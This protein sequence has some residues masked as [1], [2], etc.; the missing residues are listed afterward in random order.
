MKALPLPLLL[1]V[2]GVVLVGGLGTPCAGEEQYYMY[3][4][5]RMPCDV[6]TRVRMSI[7]DGEPVEFTTRS[8]GLF[9]ITTSAAGIVLDRP[10]LSPTP[11]SMLSL[12][13][14]PEG[15]CTPSMSTTNNSTSLVFT[16]REETTY[17]GHRC[18]KYYN[19]TD[20]IMYADAEGML[21][22]RVTTLQQTQV[23]N[24][25]A[26]TFETHRREDFVLP[27]GTTCPDRPEAFEPP[28]EDAF[29]S[30]CDDNNSGSSTLCLTGALVSLIALALT[31]FF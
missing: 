31:L 21:W 22:G 28:S 29:N 23:L 5:S 9:A 11:G 2:V 8:H 10:D 7:D 18:Y 26:R 24:Y 17:N 30:A 15:Q 14:S 12:R 20:D 13:C 27:A 3:T 16:H 1:G 4:Q 6:T 19:S 25:S